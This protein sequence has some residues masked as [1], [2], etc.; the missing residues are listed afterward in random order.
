ML[1][2][3]IWV[4]V[5][6]VLLAATAVLFFLIGRS[7]WRK[8]T[9]LLTALGEAGERLTLLNDQLQELAER[10]A[11]PAVFESPSKLRQ[12]RFLARRRSQG[13]KRA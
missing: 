12:E 3:A 13:D 4:T 5:W 6:L 8:A 11:E 2:V 9:A 7:L 10:Q 1:E